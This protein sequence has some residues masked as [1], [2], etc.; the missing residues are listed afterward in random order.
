ML[1]LPGLLWLAVFF[2]LPLYLVLAIVFG[3]LDPLFR[4]PIP[5]WNPLDWDATVFLDVLDEIRVS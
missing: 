2:V 5:V 4:T 1:T 3:R